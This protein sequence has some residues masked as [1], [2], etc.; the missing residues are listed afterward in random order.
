MYAC[1]YVDVHRLCYAYPQYC[2]YWSTSATYNITM[3]TP[4]QGSSCSES[5]QLL[6]HMYVRTYVPLSIAHLLGEAEE[7]AHGVGARGEDED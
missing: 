2:K 5:V 7:A 6:I 1:T 3:S 4:G